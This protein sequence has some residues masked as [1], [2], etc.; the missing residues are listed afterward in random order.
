LAARP[1]GA[2]AAMGLY[3]SEDADLAGAGV[4]RSYQTTLIEIREGLNLRL[5]SPTGVSRVTTT[6]LVLATGGREQ[7]RGNLLLPGT[8]PAGVLTGGAALRLLATTKRLP[9]R[10][11]VLAGTGRWANVAARELDRA[12]TTIVAQVPEL[13]KVEGWPR[14]SGIELADGQRLACDLLVLATPLL[15]WLPPALAGAASL[16]GVFVAGSAAHGEIDVYQAAAGGLA[17]G[18]QAAA[19]A[20]RDKMTR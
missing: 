9:G 5:L 19:W 4:Q 2:P 7:T 14:L 6:A 15:A 20:L 3:S 1:G 13:A 16:P 17:A 10:R 8:R 12:G 18:Q 11:A